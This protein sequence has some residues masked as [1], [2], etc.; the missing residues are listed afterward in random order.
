MV[1]ISGKTNVTPYEK[2]I[3]MVQNPRRED[4]TAP[5]ANNSHIGKSIMLSAKKI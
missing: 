4:T 2:V 5:F 3:K 1:S